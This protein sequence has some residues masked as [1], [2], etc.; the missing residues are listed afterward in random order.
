MNSWINLTALWQIIVFGLLLGAGL[1]ALFAVGLRA[2]SG[3]ESAEG[4]SAAATAGGGLAGRAFAVLSASPPSWRR[5]AGASTR[6]STRAEILRSQGDPG[7]A[8]AATRRPGPVPFRGGESARTRRRGRC[9]VAGGGCRPHPGPRAELQAHRFDG[10]P[11]WACLSSP[12]NADP[13]ATRKDCLVSRVSSFCPRRIPGPPAEPEPARHL[14]L[15]A[16]R[17][18][19][20]G[21]F[22]TLHDAQLAV[23]RE[24]GMRS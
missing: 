11:A 10:V 8:A 17:R 5:S 12:M 13:R 20:A 7:P 14:K 19:A 16:K 3:T 15:Q 4:G 21:E 18:Q 23:A 22:S 6:S 2:L 24:H 1:P 9:I